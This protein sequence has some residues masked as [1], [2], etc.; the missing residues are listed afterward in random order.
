PRGSGRS[1]AGRWEFQNPESSEALP[2]PTSDPCDVATCSCRCIPRSPRFEMFQMSH[3]RIDQEAGGGGEGRT[4]GLL[5]QSGN[6]E[7]ATDA[8]R[9]V[10]N[11]GGEVRKP[12]QLAG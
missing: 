8:H 5:R 12:V 10:E 9:P 6:A 7:R 1:A 3:L 11:A 2:K 4:L